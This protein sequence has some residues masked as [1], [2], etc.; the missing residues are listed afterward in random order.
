MSKVKNKISS[1][2]LNDLK[3]ELLNKNVIVISSKEGSYSFD[4]NTYKENL[5]KDIIPKY[6]YDKIITQASK[7]M[8]NSLLKKRQNDIFK[9][10]N[11]NFFISFISILCIIIYI[12]TTLVSQQSVN[13]K[14]MYLSIIFSA[15]AILITTVQS[16]YYF[17][18]KTR[19]YLTIDEIIKEDLSVFLNEINQIYYFTKD[20]D[21]FTYSG[22]LKF[23][24]EGSKTMVCYI[25][26]PNKNDET[27]IENLHQSFKPP[28]GLINNDLK[29]LLDS[30][31]GI[32][33]E[34]SYRAEGDG[35]LQTDGDN[36]LINNVKRYRI[37]SSISNKRGTIDLTPIQIE[38]ELNKMDIN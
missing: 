9:I 10:S 1:G 30:S 16:T 19:K 3:K 11:F 20:V 13:I 25:E 15:I 6:E 2:T 35:H 22:S 32:K 26:K 17:F 4:S 29:L 38:M 7:I 24:L 12:I 34:K 18:K 28:V 5:L 21:K 23:A 14:L 8:G 27:K 36:N 37:K 33:K 31:I